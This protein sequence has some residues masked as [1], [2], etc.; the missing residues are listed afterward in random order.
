VKLDAHSELVS[1]AKTD[2]LNTKARTCVKVGLLETKVRFLSAICS[3][4]QN[5][6]FKLYLFYLYTNVQN[7]MA[8]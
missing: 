1:S 7:I 5:V 2:S 4:H 3:E 6:K 8:R